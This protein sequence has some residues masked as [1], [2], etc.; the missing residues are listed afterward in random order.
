MIVKEALKGFAFVVIAGLAVHSARAYSP[1]TDTR[2]QGIAPPGSTL[3]CEGGSNAGNTCTT[4]GDCPSG[5]C[6]G[7]AQLQVVARGLLT[8]IADTV[9]ST[10][11]DETTQSCSEPSEG[12]SSDC[13]TEAN[14]VLSLTLEFAFNDLQ[15]M[16]A[17]SY[18]N[19]PND[20]VQPNFSP[21]WN[22]PHFE[23]T[24]SERTA[25]SGQEVLIRWGVPPK[26]IED[27]LVLLFAASP[28]QRIALSR[29]DDVPICTDASVCN[30]VG[31]NTTFADH[32]AGADVQATV[33]RWKVDIAVVGP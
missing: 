26:A 1:G 18:K 6:T 2:A 11:W 29:T 17:Q 28:A 12:N 30:H 16:F 23:S 10:A 20:E 7:I 3:V 13:E 4:S 27:E 8:I 14:A 22:E 25:F 31:S 21:G 33:R 15:Y 32:S 5:A 9:T 19:L 24:I